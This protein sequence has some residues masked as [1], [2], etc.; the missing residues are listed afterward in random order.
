MTRLLFARASVS[1]LPFGGSQRAEVV[2]ALSTALADRY[3]YEDVGKRLA[4]DLP[5][6]LARGEFDSLSDPEAFAAAVTDVLQRE[7]RDRHVWIWYR[8]GA[9]APVQ[10]AS[11]EGPMIAR[12]QMFPGKIGYLDF[13]HFV[14]MT[15]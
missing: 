12:A 5:A 1:L 7:T 6:R 11:I 15:P 14:G 3:L 10:F 2:E 4:A 8:H 9:V 13:R